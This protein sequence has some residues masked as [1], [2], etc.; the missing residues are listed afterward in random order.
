MSRAS[1]LH[2]YA[3]G[4]PP[5]AL[6][7]L[8]YVMKLT[9]TRAFTLIELLVVIGIIAILVGILLPVLRSARESASNVQCLSQLRQVGQAM[10]IYA[11]Q[12][13][14]YFPQM[15]W[16]TP[17]N[18]P[19]EVT[20]IPAA[21][22][23]PVEGREYGDVV[24]ALYRII[25]HRD[26][27]ATNYAVGGMQIFYCPSNYLWDGDNKGV[28]SSHWPEDLMVSGKIRYWYV[29]NPNGY[30]PRFHFTGPFGPNGEP[31][32]AAPNNGTIDWRFWDT[33][34][35]GDNRDEYIVK[36]NDKNPALK[37]LMTDQSR[38]SGTAG[39][40][41]FG[42]AFMHGR[43]NGVPFTGWKNNLYGDGHAESKRP[44]QSS[45]NTAGT[46]FINL[47]PSADEVQPRWG[48]AT[49]AMLW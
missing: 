14:G 21:S 16:D 20:A 9:R 35:N 40:N 38:Q 31:P 24:S 48:N 11:N 49:S 28:S 27:D 12:N 18:L 43:K 8:F 23:I 37:V 5:A 25:N 19:R 3:G 34:R 15:V 32:A 7:E 26:V 46:Q 33:N 29:G 45:F 13:R 41:S 44:R 39:T 30:Y 22:G 1:G 4:S 42:F 17:E 10:H 2:Y 36:N 47:T 6:Q